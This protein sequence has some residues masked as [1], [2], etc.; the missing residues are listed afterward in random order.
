MTVGFRNFIL[1]LKIDDDLF[2][3]SNLKELQNLFI[4][5]KVRIQFKKT[6]SNNDRHTCP[7]MNTP[8]QFDFKI[9]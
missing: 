3:T 5:L 7:K 8:S 2:D 4:K 1:N 6:P 9:T